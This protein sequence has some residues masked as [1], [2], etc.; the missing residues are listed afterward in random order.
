ME[1]MLTSSGGSDAWAM[2]WAPPP[3][4]WELPPPTGADLG[5]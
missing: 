4:V 3:V 5:A 2:D 1:A